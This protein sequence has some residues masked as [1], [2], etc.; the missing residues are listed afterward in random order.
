M[1]IFRDPR[2]IL[3]SSGY[4]LRLLELIPFHV[5][6]VSEKFA[7]DLAI[8]YIN[9]LSKKELASILRDL[10]INHVKKRK[11]FTINKR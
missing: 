4:D 5:I 8:I 10:L 11:T 1:N 2:K 9:A 3:Y 6:I 7:R